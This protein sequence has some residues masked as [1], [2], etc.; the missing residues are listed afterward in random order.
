MEEINKKK[1]V[2]DF[3]KGNGKMEETSKKLKKVVGNFMERNKF[4]RGNDDSF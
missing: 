1:V 2:R 4:C 3:D